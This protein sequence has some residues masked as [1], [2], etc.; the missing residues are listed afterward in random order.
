[1]VRNNRWKKLS[2]S[3]M[4]PEEI[5]TS[6]DIAGSHLDIEFCERLLLRPNSKSYVALNAHLKTCSSEWLHHFLEC[7]ALRMM[8]S[9]LSVMSLK[10]NASVA[11]AVLHYELV[12]GIK[13][14]LNS[15]AGMNYVFEEDE[16]LIHDM[17]LGR[18]H[19]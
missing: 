13:S 11:D 1:M 16:D 19:V 10:S 9:A 4:K 5:C 2:N 14:V 7:G 8:F 12:K 17:A 18:C 15:E 6:E 3:L